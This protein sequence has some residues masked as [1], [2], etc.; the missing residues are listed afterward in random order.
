MAD[1]R[2]RVFAT[3]V[4]PESASEGWM[5]TV[6][7]WHVKAFISP[8]H[9][10]DV[11]ADGTPKKPH[12]HLIIFFDG[13][14]NFE[15]QVKPLFD[16]IKAVGREKIISTRGYTRYL[17]H[18]DN[19]E[20]TQY[21]INEVKAF[22]GANYAFEIQ[23]AADETEQV[24]LMQDFIR[25]NEIFYLVD[26]VDYC[27]NANEVWYQI[28]T[29]KKTYFFDKYIKSFAY[30]NEHIAPTKAVDEMRDMMNSFMKRQDLFIKSNVDRLEKKLENK[31]DKPDAVI[32]DL[33]ETKGDEK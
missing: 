25:D 28:L 16:S 23:S 9:D 22:G 20:K 17:C 6:D 15:T 29:D 19:P 21:S 24:K 12:Y 14:K 7:S 2:E 18:L 27:R 10:K 33:F 30:K 8:L 31:V 13:K 4:Y 5:D 26:F 1:S 3:I 11:N 32:E